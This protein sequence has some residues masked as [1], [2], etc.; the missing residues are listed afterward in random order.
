MAPCRAPET[1]VDSSWSYCKSMASCQPHDYVSIQFNHKSS[2]RT[3]ERFSLLPLFR[4]CVAEFEVHA[5]TS[6]YSKSSRVT[7]RGSTDVQGMQLTFSQP[8]ALW[9]NVILSVIQSANFGRPG[10]LVSLVFFIC[11]EA[12][13]SPLR[14][15]PLSGK[16]V[17]GNLFL[18]C[19]PL[20]GTHQRFI[21]RCCLQKSPCLFIK[22]IL[23]LFFWKKL[24]LELCCASLTAF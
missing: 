1:F 12:V 10:P 11:R 22:F 20:A 6:G 3:R 19:C 24:T 23:S 5:P 2:Q 18:L 7:S 4:W 9:P 8:R 15:T 14:S 16:H 13:C 17:Q 21:S